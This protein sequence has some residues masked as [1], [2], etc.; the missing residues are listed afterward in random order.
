MKED[1]NPEHGYSEQWH[2]HSI[3]EA[4]LGQEAKTDKKSVRKMSPWNIQSA[5]HKESV[6]RGALPEQ[7]SHFL[8]ENI[9]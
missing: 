1:F 2:C 9:F 7:P 4:S 3:K 6:D 5:P 8:W